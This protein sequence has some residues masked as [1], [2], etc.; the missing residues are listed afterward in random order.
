MVFLRNN[1]YLSKKI[2]LNHLKN[3]GDTL[4]EN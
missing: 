4:G 1:I 2:Q 3:E